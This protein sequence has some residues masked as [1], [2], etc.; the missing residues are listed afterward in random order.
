MFGICTSFAVQC[1]FW[2]LASVPSVTTAV[3][4]ALCAD[5]KGLWSATYNRTIELL[6]M[7]R[8]TFVGDSLGRYQYLELGKPFTCTGTALCMQHSC[9]QAIT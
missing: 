5:E 2:A 9:R 6:D 4:W 3:S 1:L 7:Q 8:V